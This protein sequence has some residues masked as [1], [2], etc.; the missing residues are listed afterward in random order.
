MSVYGVLLL[1]L[2]LLPLLFLMMKKKKQ[3]KNLP[4]GPPKLPIIGNLHQLG[5]L[6]H[7]SL[8]N[9]SKKYGPVIL[10]HLGAVPTVIVSSAE[11][12]RQVLKD[13]DI[14]SC[15]RPLLVSPGKLS[16]N[17]L[18]IGFSPY[19]DYWR[20]M[21]KVCVLELFSNKRVQS[22]RFIRE[23]EVDLLIDSIS[24][25]SVSSSPVDLNEKLLSL[26]S[27][28]TCRT[29][30]GKKFQG[31]E[32]DEGNFEE[33]FHEAVAV[34][35]AFTASDF[36]PRV[37][38]IIDRLTGFQGRLE[39][40]FHHLDVFYQKVIDQH[41]NTKHE[42]DQHDILAVLLK[43]VEI[44]QTEYGEVQFTQDH[45]KAILMNIYLAGV[46]SSSTAIT[47]AMAH[48]IKEPRV[49]KKV[50]EEIRNC[51]GNKGKVTEADIEQL[52]Y[53][54]MV[55]KETLRLNPPGPLLLPRETLSH[56]KINGYD[57]YPKTQLFVNI[58]AI[59]RDPDSWKFPEEFIPERFEDGSIDYKGQNFV[60]FP[61]GAG[62]RGCPGMNLGLTMVELAL[63]NLLYCFDWK[64]P[65]GMKE[66]DV[67]MEEMAG[68]VLYKKFP[69]KLV[70]VRGQ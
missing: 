7:R 36:L 49:M 40:I 35:G 13:H 11:T 14:E 20:E 42:E 45:V 59:G 6:A 24:D 34:V 56:F 53:L 54:K 3:S 38:W 2:L 44:S 57:I 10:L 23:Q 58:W 55:V 30:F 41:L 33:V 31:N 21:R 50:Q 17:F 16:Y 5:V 62:R 69:L 19:S 60:F 9:V 15:S 1:C 18:D 51:I 4:P 29:A 25:S 47:W 46:E 37:G 63:A 52:K 61:F 65:N 43:L 12:A 67:D 39:K 68:I 64:L 27:S 28:I 26:I 66:E 48:L 22:F 32:F 70:P 8:W